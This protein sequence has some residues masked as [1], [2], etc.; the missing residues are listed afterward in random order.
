MKYFTWP[1]FAG[2]P[3]AEANWPNRRKSRR[4]EPKPANAVDAGGGLPGSGA[5]GSETWS[6]EAISE[7]PDC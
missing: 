7:T 1:F 3:C 4:V 5:Q 6:E 2:A